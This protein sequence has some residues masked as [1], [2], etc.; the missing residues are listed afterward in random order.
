VDPALKWPNDLVLVPPD[1]ERDGDRKLAGI[2]AESVVEGDAVTAL[3]VGMGINVRWRDVPDLPP[4]I[5][6]LGIALDEVGGPTDRR[7]LLA[8]VL[9]AFEA[10]YAVLTDEAGRRALIAD[11]R[12]A[13]ATLGRRVRV[14][15]PDRVLEGDAID[16]D[17]RGHLV[18]APADGS[19]DV[20]VT[21]G[22]VIHLR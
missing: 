16:L 17:E 6:A 20:A 10:R 5:R 3:V 18:V 1:G 14:E 12:A 22:D 19:D 4:E 9:T 2:L 7:A 11:Y 13:C 15:L 8:D 21:A